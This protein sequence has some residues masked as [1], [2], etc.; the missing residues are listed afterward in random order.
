MIDFRRVVARA[1]EEETLVSAVLSRPRS[2]APGEPEKITVRPVVL[3]GGLHYQWALRAGN[4]ETH[5]NLSA[6]ETGARL[7][8][9]VGGE[10]ADCHLFT[11]EADYAAHG[12][13]DG[14]LTVR[15]GPA[16]RRPAS[17]DHNRAKEYLIAEGTPCPFL[18]EIGV[19]TDDGRVRKSKYS[20]F[21]QIN[22]FLELVNDVVDALP[23]SGVLHVVDFGCGK[24]SLT[25]ALHH[26]LTQVHGREVRIVGLD[27][28]A[29]V[30]RGCQEV[31]ARLGLKGIEFRVGDIATCSVDFP[32]DLAVSLHACDTATDD[33]LARAVAWNASAIL[34]V[35]CCQHELAPT[36]HG[37][38]LDAIAQHGIMRERLAAL[39]TDALRAAALEIC[40]YKS[41]VVEFIDMEH[42]A[43]NLLIRAVRRPN[44]PTDCSAQREAY[45]RL[46]QILGLGPIHLEEAL[47]PDFVA[48]IRGEQSAAQAGAD[49][50]RGASQNGAS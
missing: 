8:R 49:P 50:A 46:K 7:G 41:Q 36:L 19:M 42:T 21:R 25:F 23:E 9:M 33:A 10:F 40:G 44:G 5:E 34:A 17:R 32:V 1:L 26:L 24:S 14:E 30:V 35:P 45:R 12:N 20:K 37:E 47:G 43:K 27:R 11:E 18:A 6:A 38:S 28:A 31:A 39:T 4:K 15:Q 13:T 2:R 22:R 16:T 48:R 3:K 29:D